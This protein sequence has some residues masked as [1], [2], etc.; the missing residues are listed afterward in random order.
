MVR[1]RVQLAVEGRRDL[2]EVSPLFN[3]SKFGRPLIHSRSDDTV[4]RPTGR[5]YE[6][7]V[8]YIWQYPSLYLLRF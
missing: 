7:N 5:L 2:L 4:H 8:A 6:A 1:G 3:Y